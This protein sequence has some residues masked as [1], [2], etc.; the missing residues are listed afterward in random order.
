MSAS[1]TITVSRV[2][3]TIRLENESTS[4]DV[5]GKNPS[6]MTRQQVID[7]I[8]NDRVGLVAELCHNPADECATARV[9]L[10]VNRSVKIPSAVYFRP[11]MRTV[12]LL[13]PDFDESKFFLKLRIVHDF[14]P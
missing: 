1:A 8:A 3:N 4:H 5:N 10:Q 9:P 11:T 13:V 2:V 14:V 6:L 12:R 7:E